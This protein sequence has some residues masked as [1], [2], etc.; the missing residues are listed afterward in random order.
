MDQINSG[1]CPLRE[2]EELFA[3]K[4]GKR[5][6]A[7][8]F[9]ICLRKGFPLLRLQELIAVPGLWLEEDRRMRTQ[10]DPEMIK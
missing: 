1:N 10:V 2:Q 6:H 5:W 8:S 4:D 7:G 9:H 3:G